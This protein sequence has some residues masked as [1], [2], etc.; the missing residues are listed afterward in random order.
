MTFWTNT[1]VIG[2]L[3]A[4]FRR[5]WLRALRIR[6]KLLFSEEAFHL[7]LAGGVGVI[8]GLVNLF[9]YYAT[10][11]V[12]LLFLRAPGDPSEVA[13]MMVG[14]ERVVIPTLGGLLAGLVLYW[15]LRLA[16]PGRSTNLLEVV[17]A[18]DGRL[19]FRSGLVKF[20]S[21]LVSI[22]SGSSIGRE[23]GITQ[24]S[25]TLASKWG[26]FAKWHPYRLRLLVG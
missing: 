20:L 9:F 4:F 23:G 1:K 6:K 5:H 25:A 17:V 12:K 13:E 10:E 22:G 19:P 2:E 16:G 15:G 3:Q 11:S 24:L 18:G 8:G 14:W 26:Q 21:S 7:L